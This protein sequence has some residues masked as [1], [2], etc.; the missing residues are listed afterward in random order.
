MK[1]YFFFLLVL[2]VGSSEC[3]YSQ[4][5]PLITSNVDTSKQEVRDIFLLYA[6]YLNSHPDSIY[7][8]PYW[9]QEET[10]IFSQDGNFP[11]DRFFWANYWVAK[12]FHKF[13]FTVLAIDKVYGKDIYKIRTL[14]NDTTSGRQWQG[15]LYD[16]FCITVYYAKKELG[17]WKLENT[18]NEETATWKTYS[19]KYITYVYPSEF[20]FNEKQADKADSFCT[21]LVD[22]FK[23]SSNP[24]TYYLCTS[25]EQMGRLFNMEYWGTPVFGFSLFPAKQIVSARATEYH[26]HEFVHMLLP[27]LKNSFL[28][29]GKATYF[30]GLGEESFDTGLKEFS[31]EIRH[32]NTITFSDIYHKKYFHMGDSKP[33]YLTAAVVYKFVYAKKGIHGIKLLLNCPGNSEDDFYKT[34]LPI[35]GMDRKVFDKRIIEYIKAYSVAAH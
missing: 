30:G 28:E 8:N 13:K 5:R 11:Q 31:N 21:A 24:F 18:I 14:I 29:E 9:N 22:T 35:L 10:P 19:T 6:H 16:P 33:F 4:I 17:E 3:A 20:S 27:R 2:L 26:I 34:V 25:A 1:K 12:E 23:I 7:S 15:K 32:N